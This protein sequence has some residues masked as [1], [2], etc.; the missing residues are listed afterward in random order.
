MLEACAEISELGQR[1]G[2]VETCGRNLEP[3]CLNAILIYGSELLLPVFPY[4]QYAPV[5][6]NIIV[7]IALSRDYAFSKAFL[8]FRGRLYSQETLDQKVSENILLL[9]K[10]YNLV[11]SP[12]L[13]N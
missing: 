10:P 9:I 8:Q 7:R 6:H 3:H 13:L 2:I 11:G 4:S 12:A 1:L 5:R